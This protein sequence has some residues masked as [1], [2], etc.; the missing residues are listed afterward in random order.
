MEFYKNIE[1][2]CRKYGIFEKIVKDIR[3]KSTK[4]VIKMKKEKNIILRLSLI[5][6]GSFLILFTIFSVVTNTV[7]KNNSLKQSEE[8]IQSEAMNTLFEIEKIFEDTVTVLNTEEALFLSLY[9]SNELIEERI[10]NFQ[11]QALASNEHIL[12]FSI[13]IDKH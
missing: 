10:V 3:C 12:G 1:N 13:I 11:K 8:Y 5:T 7:I 4:E 2:T 6:I 9:N